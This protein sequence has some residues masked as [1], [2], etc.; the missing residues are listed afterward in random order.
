MNK[1]GMIDRRF[2]KTLSSL[3]INV[4]CPSLIISSVMGDT[5]PDAHLIL[6]L[7]ALSFATYI[8]LLV[9]AFIVPRFLPIDHADDGLYGFMLTFGNVGFIGYPVVAS[10]FGQEAVFYAS[11]L[12]FPNT[13]LVF[14]VGTLLISGDYRRMRFDPKILVSPG[15]IAS[16]ISIIIVAFAI[17]VPA[18][19]CSAFALVGNLTVPSA[20]IIIGSA[21]ADMPVRKM[22][23]SRGV[24]IMTFLRLLLIP[25]VIIQICRL[26]GVDS[27]ISGI[28]AVI[29]AMPVAS[30]GTLFCIKYGRG[31]QVMAQGTFITTLLALLTIPIVAIFL[32]W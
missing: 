25:F 29:I 2:C 9:I 31:E 23:G 20:L 14:A 11:I 28:N 6:P 3:V 21:M 16:Y 26:L 17:H 12:N 18:P 27:Y 15:L 22:L 1:I 30:F 32:N 5:L 19:V 4:S 24:Y 8:F 7:L 13:L 10:I